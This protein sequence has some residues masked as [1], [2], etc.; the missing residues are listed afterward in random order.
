MNVSKMC[1]TYSYIIMKE[2]ID[3]Q[4][5]LAHF[6]N[7]WGD[8]VAGKRILKA[9]WT[10]R[11]RSRSARP[12]L[13]H[14]HPS[15]TFGAILFLSLFLF[16]FFSLFLPPIFPPFFLLLFFFTLPGCRS[17][18]TCRNRVDVCVWSSRPG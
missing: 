16:S 17:C 7:N 14:Q 8:Q 15:G 5:E 6:L 12:T 3:C 11:R 18:L 2:K 4:H 10:L 1:Y 13:F 9:S